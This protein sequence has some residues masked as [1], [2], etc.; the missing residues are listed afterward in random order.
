M[1]LPEG[2]RRLSQCECCLL[3]CP[4]LYNSCRDMVDILFKT[5]LHNC[6]AGRV[7]TPAKFEKAKCTEHVLL[8]RNLD[9]L[10]RVFL[11]KL[12]AR[13]SIFTTGRTCSSRSIYLDTNF[14]ILSV[15][16]IWTANLLPLYHHACTIHSTS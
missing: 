11:D 10:G 5:N 7:L 16:D 2:T 15:N 14:L 12:A 8:V 6:R 3:V 1:Y 13:T 4:E 9:T